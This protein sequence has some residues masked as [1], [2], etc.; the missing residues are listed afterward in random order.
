M[1]GPMKRVV[2]MNF[3]LEYVHN[4]TEKRG[5]KTNEDTT[6]TI[7]QMFIDDSNWIS[8]SA[9]DTTRIIKDCNTFVSFHGL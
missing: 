5:Y 6:E 3:W 9:E 8:T 4:T 2:F 7:G 1:G